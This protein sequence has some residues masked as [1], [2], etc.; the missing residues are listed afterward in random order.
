MR[1]DAPIDIAS[2]KPRVPVIASEWIRV[3][4]YP[5]NHLNDFCIFQDTDGIWHS[6]GI[7]GTGTWASETS[8]FHCSST[9]LLEPFRTHKPI[10]TTPPPAHLP[11]QKHAPFVVFHEGYYHLFYRR[12]PGTI[13]VVRSA[14]P[15]DW[16]DPGIPVFE[17]RDARDICIIKDNDMF[18]MYYCQSIFIDGFYR[19]AILMR[20]STDLYAWSGAETVFLDTIE[21]REHSYLESPYVVGRP[22]GYY[23]FIRHR[24]LDE[25]CSTVVIFSDSPNEFPSGERTWF[26]ELHHVHAP[27][28]VPHEGKYYIARVSGPQHGNRFAPEKGGWIEIAELRFA[29][30][31]E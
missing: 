27:E 1:I 12:P 7:M 25:T 9:N 11:P 5:E 16:P 22:E 15:F 31:A 2:K 17:E 10:L 18:F 23:L 13:L 30:G 6:M 21:T 26:A 28:I 14:D 3:I 20:K 19:S 29:D 4:D 24:L 8:L